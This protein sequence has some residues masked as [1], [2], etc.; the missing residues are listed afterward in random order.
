M[1]DAQTP[2]TVTIRCPS[3]HQQEVPA[4]QLRISHTA[5]VVVGVELDCDGCEE[6]VHVEQSPSA[7]AMLAE[8][9]VALADTT[10]P[11]A[12]G[13]AVSNEHRRSLSARLLPQGVE[14]PADLRS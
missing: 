14:N 2:R 10:L 11:D 13:P 7:L 1:G 8:L 3:G 9:G 6:R 12:A 5:T 4:E